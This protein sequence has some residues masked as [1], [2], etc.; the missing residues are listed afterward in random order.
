MVGAGGIS[1]GILWGFSDEV[2]GP[3]G[4]D[5]VYPVLLAGVIYDLS[6]KQEHQ[7]HIRTRVLNTEWEKQLHHTNEWVGN[8]SRKAKHLLQPCFFFEK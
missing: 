7:G 4:H 2:E 6:A 3:V 8:H 1:P 5:D